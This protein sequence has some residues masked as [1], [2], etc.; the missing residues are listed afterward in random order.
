MRIKDSQGNA[1]KYQ[2][3]E[4]DVIP[5]FN[6]IYWGHTYMK[7]LV[8]VTVPASGYSTYVL[9]E[10]DEFKSELCLPK[11]PRVEYEDRFILENELVKVVFDS[12]TLSVVSFVDK[13]SGK[14]FASAGKPSGLFR[15][16][17]EDDNK[18]MTAWVVGMSCA[19]LYF[20]IESKNK[21]HNH[22]LCAT[23]LKAYV[24]QNIQAG[25]AIEKENQ[26]K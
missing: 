12:K 4:N 17:K 1:T 11:E 24:L 2:M 23:V 25:F 19:S 14:D 22:Y 10:D 6:Q 5:F 18:G 8:D 9:S 13:S 20:C 3:L 26:T 7:L 16:I 21:G 15:L